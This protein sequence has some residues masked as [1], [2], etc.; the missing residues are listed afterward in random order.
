MFVTAT[1]DYT[2]ADNVRK[3][4]QETVDKEKGES[5][6]NASDAITDQTKRAQGTLDHDQDDARTGNADG[7]S[8]ADEATDK[9]TGN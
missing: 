5:V 6:D 7:K 4:A 1:G 2:M 9:I 8:E 3:H